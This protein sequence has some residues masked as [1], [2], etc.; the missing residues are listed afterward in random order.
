LRD[1][2][3]VYGQVRAPFL[4][5]VLGWD[6]GQRT[7]DPPL[8][9]L[10]D[11]SGAFWPPPWT[12]E[13]VGLVR[14][15]LAQVAA[16][17]PP[18]GLPEMEAF[19]EE[20]T[21]WVRVAADPAP[22]LALGLCAPAWLA[23]ALPTLLRAE[24]A[25]V[26]AGEGLAHLD[27]RSDNICFVADGGGGERAVLVDWNW[28]CRGNPRVDVAAWLPSLRAEG[29]PAPEAVLPGEPELAAC[30]SGFFASRAGLPGSASL[31]ALQRRQL[32]TALPWASLALGLPPPVPAA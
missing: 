19:R 23:A 4:P 14:V 13:R 30:M 18:P 10:E 25:V 16:T 24:A 12:A 26:L 21:G 17:P 6:D 20:L 8:L 5:R 29:G 11:L 1:E 9:V 27:V 28:A 31:R 15:A 22:F 2:W 3:R 32:E 7:G